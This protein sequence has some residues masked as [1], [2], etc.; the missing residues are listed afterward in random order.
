M[1][2][3]SDLQP[4]TSPATFRPLAGNTLSFTVTRLWEAKVKQRKDS[5][6]AQ[7][8]EQAA[9]NRRVV[10]SSPTGGAEIFG[11]ERAC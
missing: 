10:G 11:S 5:S 1:R 3:E 2:S 6:V 9:V 7:L 8:V 4:T